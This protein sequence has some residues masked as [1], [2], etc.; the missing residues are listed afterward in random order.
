MPTAENSGVSREGSEWGESFPHELPPMTGQGQAPDRGRR[1]WVFREKGVGV[2]G[3]WVRGQGSSLQDRFWQLF[4]QGKSGVLIT[5]DRLGQRGKGQAT[6]FLSPLCVLV[7]QSLQHTVSDWLFF[8]QPTWT[9]FWLRLAS[10]FWAGAR[11]LFQ[12]ALI[13]F[14]HL[15]AR[16]PSMPGS[17]L[18]TQYRIKHTWNTAFSKPQ[19]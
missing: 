17:R 2:S 7:L 12:L 4:G 11:T 1:S 13:Q 8:I 14:N 5:G 15:R 16:L 10:G 9:A 19:R 18:T 3:G 6:I